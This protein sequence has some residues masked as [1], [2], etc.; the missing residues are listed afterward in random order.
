MV[1]CCVCEIMKQN[2]DEKKD[3]PVSYSIRENGTLKDGGGDESMICLSD[4]ESMCPSPR[5]ADCL[6]PWFSP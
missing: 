1:K 3:E 6:L 2:C 4:S 5:P